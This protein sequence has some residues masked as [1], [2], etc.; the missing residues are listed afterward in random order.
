MGVS[1][2]TVERELKELCDMGLVEKKP[3]PDHLSGNGYTI[4][5]D[6]GA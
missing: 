1:R 2:R 5:Y 4:G 6:L 3:L